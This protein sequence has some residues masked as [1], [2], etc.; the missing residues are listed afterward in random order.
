MVCLYGVFI[1]CVYMVCLYFGVLIWFFYTLYGVAH[2]SDL[3][4][5]IM[6]HRVNSC[7]QEN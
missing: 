4:G 6:S 1:W 2:W 7:S 5:L 3:T